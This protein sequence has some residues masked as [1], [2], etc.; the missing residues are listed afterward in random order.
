MI[1]FNNE[2]GSS[3]VV[4]KNGEADGVWIDGE[5]VYEYDS[6]HKSRLMRLLNL[7]TN[8]MIST[9]E[10][11]EAVIDLTKEDYVGRDLPESLDDIVF[12]NQ[13][14]IDCVSS[15]GD[16]E[17]LEKSNEYLIVKNFSD[18]EEKVVHQESSPEIWDVQDL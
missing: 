9:Y 5:K 13:V 2:T 6:L 11:E 17:K 7:H 12:A 10:E 16:I 15:F 3:V 1:N 4:V 18:F 8:G 14:D